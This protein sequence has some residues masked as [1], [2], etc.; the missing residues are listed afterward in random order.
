MRLRIGP[1]ALAAAISGTATRM[2]SQPASSNLRICSTVASTS[3]VLV[4]HMD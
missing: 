2:I 1:T 4:E 3:W